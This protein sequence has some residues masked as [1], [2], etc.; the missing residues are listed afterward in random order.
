MSNSAK[1]Q[2]G[3]KRRMKDLNM[4]DIKRTKLSGGM[5]QSTLNQMVKFNEQ[6]FASLSNSNL[7]PAERD[8]N[9][10]KCIQRQQMLL[11]MKAEMIETQL[12]NTDD[13][14]EGTKGGKRQEMNSNFGRPGRG[15]PQRGDLPRDGRGPQRGDLLR[16]GPTRGGPPRDWP[17]PMMGMGFNRCGMGG[18]FPGPGGRG[19]PSGPRMWAGPFHPPHPRFFGNQGMDMMNFEDQRPPKSNISIEEK[20]IFFKNQVLEK[21]DPNLSGFNMIM[22]CKRSIEDPEFSPFIDYRFERDRSKDPVEIT[23]RLKMNGVYIA[24]ATG[25]EDKLVKG[26]TYR[27]AL[28][29]LHTKTVSEIFYNSNKINAD[30]AKAKGPGTKLIKHH[31][32]GNYIKDKL[33]ILNKRLSRSE[34]EREVIR[35]FD[36]VC[37]MNEISV[38]SILYRSEESDGKF[39]NQIKCELYVDDLLMGSARSAERKDAIRKAYVEAKKVIMQN[40][41]DACISENKRLSKL[42]RNNE[43]ILDIV[44][45]GK[46]YEMGSNIGNLIVSRKSRDYESYPQKELV[47]LIQTMERE[48]VPYTILERTATAN[49]LLLEYVLHTAERTKECRDFRCLIYLNTKLIAL[50]TGQNKPQAKFTAAE[51]ALKELTSRYSLI[52]YPTRDYVATTSNDSLIALAHNLKISGRDITKDIPEEFNMADSTDELD[53]YVYRILENMVLEYA[54]VETLEEMIFGPDLPDVVIDLLVKKCKEWNIDGNRRQHNGKTYIVIQKIKSI[55]TSQMSDFLLTQ[56]CFQNGR[57]TLV[58]LRQPKGKL[59]VIN[60]CSKEVRQYMMKPDENEDE[61]EEMPEDLGLFDVDI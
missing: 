57:Y 42:D 34:N 10:K 30:I 56:P 20:L 29:Y 1:E 35:D 32:V 19:G 53:P 31:F 11:E 41:L 47:V 46:F 61:D 36:Y 27:K 55:T 7:T 18:R 16:D 45:K 8:E 51:N 28:Y 23:G 4:E 54:N 12:Q 48:P 26:M 40:K 25:T 13:P 33:K 60:M 43:N 5:D 38:T 2:G 22:G 6:A 9:M 14:M 17:G 59:Q 58:Q 15:G 21:F 52:E 50:A 44:N 37:D 3:G 39:E 49:G 24:T